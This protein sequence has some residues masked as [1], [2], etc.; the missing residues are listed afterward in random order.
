MFDHRKLL[1][2]IGLGAGFIAGEPGSTYRTG[3]LSRSERLRDRHRNLI[4]QIGS[5][6]VRAFVGEIFDGPASGA[7]IPGLV[8]PADLTEDGLPAGLEIDAP[9]M[10]D[11]RL[12]AIGLAIEG[13][14]P[15][16][17]PPGLI[18]EGIRTDA[19]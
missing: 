12:L 2:T 3:S 13:V 4:G 19:P 7:G 11:R 1:K 18:G 5:P 14:L 16:L 9:V 15:R 8:I 17:P 10:S 6:D